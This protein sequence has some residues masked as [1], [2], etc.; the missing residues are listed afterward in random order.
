MLG[1]DKPLSSYVARHTWATQAKR[2]GVSLSVISE[3]MGHTSEN[4][5]RIYPVSYTHLD[6]YKRQCQARLSFLVPFFSKS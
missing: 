4:T 1:L 3:A 5:T 6:V 2:Q